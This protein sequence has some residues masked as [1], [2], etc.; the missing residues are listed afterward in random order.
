MITKLQ[1]AEN[2]VPSENK[3]EKLSQIIGKINS[4]V[5]KSHANDVAV[6]ADVMMKSGKL[7]TSA[8]SNTDQEFEYAYFDNIGEALVI[9]LEE[10]Q[11]FLVG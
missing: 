4:I 6:K 1:T 9:G 8:K 3:E 5:G 2:Y 7:K 10:N 11:D